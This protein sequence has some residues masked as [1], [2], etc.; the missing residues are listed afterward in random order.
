MFLAGTPLSGKSNFLVKIAFFTAIYPETEGAQD[1]R[2]G[3]ESRVDR[4]SNQTAHEW[5]RRIGIFGTIAILSRRALRDDRQQKSSDANHTT[6]E[7]A[8]S[9]RKNGRK[10]FGEEI[11]FRPDLL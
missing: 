8:L 2:A 6:G 5:N 1:R 7:L 11:I 3:F 4:K 10:P 9:D